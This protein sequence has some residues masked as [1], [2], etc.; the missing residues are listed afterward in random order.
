MGMLIRTGYTGRERKQILRVL[1]IRPFFRVFLRQFL[2]DAS[3]AYFLFRNT[4]TD[5]CFCQMMSYAGTIFVSSTTLPVDSIWLSNR[6]TSRDIYIFNGTLGLACLMPRKTRG[7]VFFS[8]IRKSKSNQSQIKVKSKSNQSKLQNETARS[9]LWQRRFWRRRIFIC[10][11]L[12][13]GFPK[14]IHI[15]IRRRQNRRC[16]S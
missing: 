7:L 6:S 10:I 3:A 13:K 16:H 11:F 15:K 5:V 4:P 12:V 2:Q 8:G 1:S 14:N 9:Q